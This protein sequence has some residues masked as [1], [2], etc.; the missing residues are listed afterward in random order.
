MG[1]RAKNRLK[2][3]TPPADAPITTMGK[4]AAGDGASAAAIGAAAASLSADF[5]LRGI[6]AALGVLL[7]ERLLGDLFL[8]L[9]ARGMGLFQLCGRWCFKAPKSL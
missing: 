2:A 7:A 4:P 9:T 3:S 5:A 6:L 8:F 1:M